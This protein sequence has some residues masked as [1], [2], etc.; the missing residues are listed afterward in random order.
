MSD[1]AHLNVVFARGECLRNFLYSGALADVR[2]TA[3]VS[4]LSVIPSGTI[5]ELL[6]ADTDAL[7]ELK[8]VPQDYRVRLTRELLGMAHGR[9]LWSEAAK[10]RWRFRRVEANTF[11]KWLRL[12]GKRLLCYPFTTKAG[13]K[14]LH[15]LESWAS[16]RWPH[17]DQLPRIL[18]P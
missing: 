14:R 17:S 5:E 18:P 4:M 8:A 1:Q 9:R 13:I 16:A 2:E 15:R 10:A 6:A 7:E 12:W 11:A 3:R